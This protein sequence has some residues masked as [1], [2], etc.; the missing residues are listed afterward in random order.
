MWILLQT[1]TSTLHSNN[2]SIPSAPHQCHQE[3]EKERVKER[4]REEGGERE[5]ER[6]AEVEFR[7]VA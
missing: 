4:E 6:Q 2:T 5:R 3:R 1:I 7:A